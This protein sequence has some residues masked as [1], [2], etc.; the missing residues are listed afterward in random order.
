MIDGR[1]GRQAVQVPVAVHVPDPDTF[2][3]SQNNVQR[4]IIVRAVLFFQ[5]YKVTLFHENLPIPT[6]FREKLLS[7]EALV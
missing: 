5:S 7:P 2:P 6:G 4:F 3:P 1:I